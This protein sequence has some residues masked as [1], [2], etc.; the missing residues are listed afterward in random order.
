MR[1]RILLS[2]VVLAA[3]FTCTLAS[4]P[5]SGEFSLSV[6]R[7]LSSL[8]ELRILPK[9]ATDKKQ[10]ALL[11]L[12]DVSSIPDDWKKLMAQTSIGDGPAAGSDKYVDPGMLRAYLC[13]FIDSQGGDSSQV[14]IHLPDKIVVTRQSVQLSQEQIEAIFRKFVVENAPWKP[15]DIV[16]QRINF[17]GLPVL[18]AGQMTYEVAPIQRERFVGNVSISVNFIVNGEKVRTLG[19][20]GK[21]DVYQNV[22]HASRALRQNDVITPVDIDLQRINISD[23]PDRYVTQPDQALNKRL[24]RNIGLHQ[25]ITLK[26][27]DKP[28][29]LKRGDAVTIVYSQ[30][31]IHVTAKGQAKEDGTEGAT[32]R[33]SNI[34]SKK[35]IS[36]RVLDSETVQAVR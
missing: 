7:A 4:G 32:I 34:N 10:V 31:G 12:C 30:P 29:V 16:I 26:D 9:V 21:V 28:L 6:C 17:T 23:A 13:Q 25:P 20:T 33:I 8:A 5:E 1:L 18:P 14:Q 35:T 11:D 15:E 27:V 19:V 36:C 3:F 2:A 22:Y 24:M